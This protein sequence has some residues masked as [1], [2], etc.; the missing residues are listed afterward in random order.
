M[1]GLKNKSG[2]G[3]NRSRYFFGDYSDGLRYRASVVTLIVNGALDFGLTLYSRTFLT[4]TLSFLAG[5][6]SPAR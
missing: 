2:S 3:M 1:K 5:V 4:F 6:A